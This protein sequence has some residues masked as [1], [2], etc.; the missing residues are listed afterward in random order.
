MTARFVETASIFGV[1]LAVIALLAIA[2]VARL[3]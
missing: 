1:S 2:I 3:A